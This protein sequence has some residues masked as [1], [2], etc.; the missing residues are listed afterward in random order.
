MPTMRARKFVKLVLVFVVCVTNIFV[1]SFH[2]C[3]KIDASIFSVFYSHL[4]LSVVVVVV[5]QCGEWR[6]ENSLAQYAIIGHISFGYFVV[7]CIKLEI[8]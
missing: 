4:H 7:L 8:T 6:R 2:H 3:A 1:R 5:V